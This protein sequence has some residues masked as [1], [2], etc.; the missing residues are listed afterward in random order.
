M[1]NVKNYVSNNVYDGVKFISGEGAKFNREQ[2]L[3]AFA[4]MYEDDTCYHIALVSISDTECQC[5]DCLTIYD[6]DLDFKSDWPNA[7][8]G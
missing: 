7:D 8:R 2:A 1:S 3:E 5:M 6:K 4:G